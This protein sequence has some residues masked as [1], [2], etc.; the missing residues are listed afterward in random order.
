VTV[1]IKSTEHCRVTVT[2][3]RT[4]HFIVTVTINDTEHFRVTVNNVTQ[5]AIMSVCILKVSVLSAAELPVRML[6][7]VRL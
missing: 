6:S 7:K 3:S 5:Q 1:T 4:E 2:I